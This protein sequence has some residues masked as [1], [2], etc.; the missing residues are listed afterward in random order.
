MEDWDKTA[1]HIPTFLVL[2]LVTLSIGVM[3]ELYVK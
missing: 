3:L 2:A 1:H